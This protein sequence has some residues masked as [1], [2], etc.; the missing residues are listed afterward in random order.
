MSW[1]KHSSIE[2]TETFLRFSDAE[3]LRWPAGPYVVESRDDSRL[4]GATGLAFE[5][6][7][8]ASTGYIFART[9][10][11]RGYAT[12]TL[13]AII[14]IAREVGVIRLYA[15]CHVDHPASTR[16]LEK[17]SFVREGILRKHSEFPN[18]QPGVPCDVFCYALI[19]G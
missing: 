17:C 10:W 11:G 15:I 4:L 16:V 19:V 13:Q 18:V 5:T 6:A 3:W 1:P 8:R 7:T 12:E 2:A 9:E 14:G